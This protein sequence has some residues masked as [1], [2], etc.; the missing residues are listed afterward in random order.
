MPFRLVRKFMTVC[1]PMSG[2]WTGAS[3]LPRKGGR[4]ARTKRCS[5]DGGKAGWE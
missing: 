4:D 2:N 1:L 3:R 5:A